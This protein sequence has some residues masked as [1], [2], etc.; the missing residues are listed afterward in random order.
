MRRLAIYGFFLILTLARPAWAERIALLLSENSGPYAEFATTFTSALDGERWKITTI[1]KIQPTERSDLIVSAG[2]EAF[3][4]ALASTAKEPI[5]AT[6]LP[7]QTYEKILA[8][9]GRTRNRGRVTAIYLDQP[10]SRQAAFLRQLLPEQKRIGILFSDETRDQITLYRQAFTN[11]GLNME[12]EEST[13][14]NTLLPS[15]TTLLSRAQVLLAIPDSTIYKRDNI[16][17]ILVTSYRHQR[18][19]VAFSAPFVSAGA[20]AALY[21]TPAQIARQTA[22][23]ITN[24]GANL[25]LPLP[26][27]MPPSQF[28]IAI[29]ENVASALGLNTPDENTIRR[30]MLAEGDL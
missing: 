7:R 19:I 28:A 1:S 2:A 22:A 14:F 11:A 25:P 24:S 10:P 4:L 13:T 5:I 23:L 12:S 9:T 3:R 16:K 8:E 29:N 21:S 26:P 15:I 6:L 27:P 18:P 17:A 30:A 20:L